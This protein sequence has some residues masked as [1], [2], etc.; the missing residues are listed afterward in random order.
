M[1]DFFRFL[2]ES[3]TPY[4]AN[5]QLCYYLAERD[6][7]P[8]DLQKT[9]DL[10]KN[11][12]YFL[13][14]GSYLIAFKMPDELNKLSVAATHLDSPAL[15]LKP[16]PNIQTPYLTKLS[17]A[18]YGSP[19]YSTWMNRKLGLAGKVVYIDEKGNRK[20]QLISTEEFP[21]VITEPAI[22]LDRKINNE[23]I[24]PLSLT[25]LFSLDSKANLEDLLKKNLSFKTLLDFDLTFYPLEKPYSLGLHHEMIA[26]PR[27]D[28][29]ASAFCSAKAIANAENKN[30]LLISIFTNHEEVGS[31]SDEGAFSSFFSSVLQKI[32]IDKEQ[33]F[34]LKQKALCA[35]CDLTHALDPDFLEKFD[36][37]N[38]PILGKGVAI[39]YDSQKS[40]A[41]TVESSAY[42]IE[43]ANKNNLNLQKYHV[44]SDSRAGGT[45]GSIFSAKEGISTIDMGIPC[46]SMH[47]ATEVIAKKDF[48][49]Q[50]LLLEAFFKHTEAFAL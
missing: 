22:H 13:S 38:T 23:G 33:F 1:Q 40:Y 32:C 4:H 50:T 5:K 14:H 49:E 17:T 10:E 27:L 47:G 2:E 45:I 43:L 34:A 8:L 44:R 12:G 39:K 42:F 25:P 29:L 9:W 11:Q 18:I 28:N 30:S 16:E 19:I 20:S 41:T 31:R 48:E 3:K 15:K 46:L 26:S 36:T 6:F 24:N 37:K 21:F 35:S 7:F